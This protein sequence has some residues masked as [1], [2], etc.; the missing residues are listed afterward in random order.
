MLQNMYNF[1]TLQDHKVVSEQC[2]ENIF[3]D[4]IGVKEISDSCAV[5]ALIF[6]ML[7]F[8]NVPEVT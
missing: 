1:F 2:D 7:H 8:Y 3:E 5:H 6:S 4:V